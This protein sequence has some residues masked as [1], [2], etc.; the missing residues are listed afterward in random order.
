MSE[1][2]KNRNKDK[3]RQANKQQKYN[4]EPKHDVEFAGE[5]ESEFLNLDN[6]R[7]KRKRES[8]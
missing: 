5:N 7:N 4:T 8:E 1:D 3:G 2:N 6:R